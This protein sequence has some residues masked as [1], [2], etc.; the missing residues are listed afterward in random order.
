MQC[1]P[2]EDGAARF[3]YLLSSYSNHSFEQS[4]VRCTVSGQGV[5][6]LF[7]VYL[8]PYRRLDTKEQYSVFLWSGAYMFIFGGTADVS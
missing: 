8:F 3:R 1:L 6:C 7:A 2:N 4:F 5:P